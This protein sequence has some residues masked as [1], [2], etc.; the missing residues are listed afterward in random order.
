MP[1]TQNAPD[2]S[3]AT[4]STGTTVTLPSTTPHSQSTFSKLMM[5]LEA[6]EPVLLAG[7]SPF[8]KNP[9]T[10][11]IVATEAPVAAN[12]FAALAAL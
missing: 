12:L 2:T 10:Q 11:Q 7:A 8:I 5:I 9:E 3:T 6:L 4:T 1:P